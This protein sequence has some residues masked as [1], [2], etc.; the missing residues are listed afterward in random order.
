MKTKTRRKKRGSREGTRRD[1]RNK[2]TKTNQREH[3]DKMTALYGK[4]KL[5]EGK[6]NSKA[7]EV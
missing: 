1:R 5:G 3:M 6:R 7:G 4:Q 2:R